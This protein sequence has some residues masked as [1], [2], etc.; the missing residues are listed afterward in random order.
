VIDRRTLTRRRLIGA[1]GGA[2]AVGALG[3][4][5]GLAGAQRPGR[6]KSNDDYGFGK[7]GDI[8]LHRIGIQLFTV[9]DLLA[10]NELDMPGTFRLLA[11]AGYA[12]IELGGDYDGRPPTEVRRLGKARGLRVVSNHFGPRALIQ[13]TWYDPSERARFFE[14]AH[15]LGLRA[16]GTGHSYIAPRTVEGYKEMA[17]AF[18]VWGRDAVRNGFRYFF[19]H[20]HDVEFTIV[21]GRPLFDILLEETDPRYVKFE[22]DL[23]W[24]SVSGEDPYEYIRR[25]PERF[26]M[27][28]VKDIRWDPNGPRVA[29]D[30]TANAGHRFRFVDV[31][32]G[33]VNWRRI[34]SA[35]RN[36][37]RHWYFVEHDD[38]GADETPDASSPRPRNPAGSANTAWTSR[39]YLANLEIRRRRQRS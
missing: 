4:Y 35:L 27:F 15:A 11:D 7:S 3:P 39:K 38:A 34:F 14:E 33:V 32:K 1:A 36:P 30:G 9:R 31:G 17:A 19:F 6:G 23:G 2:A 5:S 25:D 28:H 20:N 13:N 10:D 8:P 21:N 22:L 29:A 24:M 18:N 12:G 16:I 37:G 26:P